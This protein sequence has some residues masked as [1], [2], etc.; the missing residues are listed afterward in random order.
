MINV[1]VF[2]S[3]LARFGLAAAG[4]RSKNVKGAECPPHAT[5]EFQEI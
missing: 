5:I 2:D 1:E 4:E 3:T